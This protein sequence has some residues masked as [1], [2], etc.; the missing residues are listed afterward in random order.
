MPLV[1][2]WPA[3]YEVFDHLQVVPECLPARAR[4]AE[5]LHDEPAIVADPSKGEEPFEVHDA[6]FERR[7]AGL[8]HAA[9][10]GLVEGAFFRWM[11]AR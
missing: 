1:L 5:V 4:A 2:V 3:G 6:V 10:L 11:C 8:P 9:T 7:P